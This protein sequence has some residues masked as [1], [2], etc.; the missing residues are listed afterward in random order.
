MKPNFIDQWFIDLAG[1][2]EGFGL[3]LYVVITVI[4]SAVLSALIGLERPSSS[5]WSIAFAKNLR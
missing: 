2:F 4:I 3:L 1:K 5:I